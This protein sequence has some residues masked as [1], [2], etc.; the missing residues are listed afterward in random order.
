[1]PVIRIF[2]NTDADFNNYVKA[3]IGY[4]A[5]PENNNRLSIS[6]ENEAEAARLLAAWNIIF[7]KSRNL[8]TRT[9][10]VIKEKKDQRKALTSLL[11]SIY[12]DIPKSALTTA[13]RA[14]LRL[15]ERRRPTDAPTPTTAPLG[16]VSTANRLQHTISY[17]N[18]G[19]EDRAKPRGVHGCQI[20]YATAADAG[21]AGLT[22]LVSNSASPYTVHW[23]DDKVGK[24]IY[25]WLRWENTRGKVGPWGEV[26]VATVT[27]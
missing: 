9:A 25:Y 8:A 14:S 21:E 16:H 11:R 17:H 13:D 3:A 10:V 24:N 7:P 27:A 20:W 18:T 5:L 15:R 4:L 1:M 26:I 2:P 12:N 19:S 23:P 22:F 6:P